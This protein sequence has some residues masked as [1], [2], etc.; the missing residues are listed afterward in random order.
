MVVVVGNKELENL[1]RKI[2][3]ATLRM[4][5]KESCLVEIVEMKIAAKRIAPLTGFR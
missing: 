4:K 1:M 2:F 5:S 3:F